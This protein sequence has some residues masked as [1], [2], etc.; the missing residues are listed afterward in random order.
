MERIVFHIDVNNAFL[1]WTAIDLLNKGY[2]E[3]IRNIVSVIGGDEKARNG[4]VLSKSTPAKKYG[5]KTAE[6]LYSARKKYKDVKVFPADHKYYSMMSKKMF[7]LLSNYS[8]DIEVASVDECYLDYGKIKNLYGDE[9]KFAY[10]LK[11][12]IKNDLGF[13]VNIGIA[14]N[15]LCAK[16]ASDFEKPDRVHTLYMNEIKE[17]M[18]PLPIGDLFG[19][20]KSSAEKLK[21]IGINTIGELATSSEERIRRIFKNQSN[22]VIEIAN[23]IDNSELELYWEPKG[24][25]NEITLPKDERNIEVLNEKLLMLS[26]MVSKRLRKEEK[27]ASTICVIL[28]DNSFIRKSHQRSLINP[29]NIT[30]EIYKNSKEILKEFYKGEGIRL[31][32]IRLDNL[33]NKESHQIDLFENFEEKNKEEKID[34]II[35]E[36]NDKLGKNMIIKASIKNKEK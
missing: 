32:G 4:I 1:S 36:I 2:K 22:H 13:T 7:N 25:S 21:E 20:G 5:I 23:G 29:T 26:E 16:M 9:L 31:I 24:I 30:S 33:T 10:M 6:T 17:K 15:K 34:K 28:K 12:K 18:W 19:I 35:D 8:P 27:Y 3:D 14:N 11:D